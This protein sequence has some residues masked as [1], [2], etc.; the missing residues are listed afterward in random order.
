ML[1]QVLVD[2]ARHWQESVKSRPVEPEAGNQAHGRR[3]IASSP[4]S[5][6]A[7]FFASSTTT[8]STRSGS[9]P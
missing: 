2:E 9:L 3:R 5:S 8:A 6:P 7:A 1:D 4:V